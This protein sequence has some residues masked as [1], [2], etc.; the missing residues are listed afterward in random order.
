M[1]KFFERIRKYNMILNPKKCTFGV[2][3]GK[4]LGFL[5]TQ[6][7]IEVNPTKIKVITEMTTPRNE[8]EV[9]G[10]LGRIQFIS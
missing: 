9:R 4:L 6:R 7:G 3:A 8:K 10:F 2:T 5:V 1:R